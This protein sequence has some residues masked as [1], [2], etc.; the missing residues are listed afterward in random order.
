MYADM[1]F[2]ICYLPK[3]K[4]NIILIART[5][6]IKRLYH[7]EQILHFDVFFK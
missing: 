4:F 5:N 7:D 3:Y 6:Y 2:F 1:Q